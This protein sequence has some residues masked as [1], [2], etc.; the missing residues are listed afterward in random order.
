M[1][2]D[3]IIYPLL[4]GISSSLVATS[5][6]IAISELARRFLLPW[7]AD[8]IY[9]GVRIDGEWKIDEIEGVSAEDAKLTMVFNLKQK[10]ENISGTYYHNGENGK[11]LYTVNGT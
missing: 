9:R 1:N 10:S 11:M 5:I 2:Q 3:E 4:I 8:K 6:F 7:I